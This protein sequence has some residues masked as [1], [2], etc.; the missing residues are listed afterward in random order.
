MYEIVTA[1]SGGCFALVRHAVLLQLSSRQID[2]GSI[3]PQKVHWRSHE[4]R[5]SSHL[6]EYIPGRDQLWTP[7]MLAA[8]AHPLCLHLAEPADMQ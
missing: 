6:L 7:E 8:G 3:Q 5:A 4:V 1:H 2:V